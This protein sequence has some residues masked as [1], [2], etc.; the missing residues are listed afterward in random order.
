MD[1]QS[2]LVSL[3]E[4]AN[5]YNIKVLSPDINTSETNFIARKGKIYFGMAG[6]KGVGVAAVNS[7]VSVRKEKPFTSVF[8][9]ALR[10]EHCNKRILE[11]LICSGAFDTIHSLK[12]RSQLFAS[13]D[14]ILDYSKKVTARN[15]N[16]I[17]DMFAMVDSITTIPTPELI[18]A[19]E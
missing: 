4:E 6:I 14:L 1:K 18:F 9:F 17:E 15:N 16:V 8:D 12:I 13:V 2:T 10:T 7:I 11:A 3:I 5:K 19:P